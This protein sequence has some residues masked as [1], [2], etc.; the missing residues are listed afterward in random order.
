MR[1]VD[2]VRALYGTVLLLVGPTALRRRARTSPTLVGAVRI[3]GVR[4]LLQAML[5]PK[6]S[7]TP[8]RRLAATVDGLHAT[9][10]LAFAVIEP[11]HRGPALFD[12]AVAMGLGL[13]STR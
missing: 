2:R 10:D 3:L 4:H 8:T 11:R 6:I 7:S 1:P 12:A 5:E 9:S 13:W